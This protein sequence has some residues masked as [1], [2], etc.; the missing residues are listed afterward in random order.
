MRYPVR[1]E[2]KNAFQ[3]HPAK[4]RGR[5]DPILHRARSPV[6]TRQN[7]SSRALFV[8]R[9]CPATPAWRFP[10]FSRRSAGRPFGAE[11][12]QHRA[13]NWKLVHERKRS[14]S[15]KGAGQ[16]ERVQGR[17][18][19]AFR[20]GGPWGSRKKR[21]VKE[22]ILSAGTN[23][24]V[25]IGE[26]CASNQA[27]RAGNYRRARRVRQHVGRCAAPPREGAAVRTGVR[28][29]PDSASDDAG[30]QSRQASRRSRSR[31]SR[32]FSSVVTPETRLGDEHHFLSSGKPHA[33]SEH[34]EIERLDAPQQLRCR[35]ARDATT[36]RDCL[37]RSSRARQSLLG[38]IAR[39][40]PIR[41]AAIREPQSVASR[42]SEIFGRDSVAHQIFFG[43]ID[44][45]EFANLHTRLRNDVGEL[46]SEAELFRRDRARAHRGSRTRE[47]R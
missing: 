4:A 9:A 35:Y 36:R 39:R 16:C 33:L 40:A 43:Q 23:A 6:A 42:R 38:T 31:F 11:N 8:S 44:A 34:R 25:K 29:Q 28:R 2:K 32:I 47:Y 10:P 3:K 22:L 17:I 26:I 45:A 7:R 13:R 24:P 41:I 1:F 30:C 27:S 18:P 12:I 46:K 21:R 19:A 20:R 5:C 14:E 37:H 15:G